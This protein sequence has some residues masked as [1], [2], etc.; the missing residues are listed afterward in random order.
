MQIDSDFL[1]LASLVAVLLLAPLIWIIG[2][3]ATAVRIRRVSWIAVHPKLERTGEEDLSQGMRVLLGRLAAA[4]RASGF[5]P[6]ESVHA[7][8]FSGFGAWTQVLY[9]HPTTGERASFINRVRAPGGSELQLLLA[10]ECPP[11]P[12]VITGLPDGPLRVDHDLAPQLADLIVRHRD[13]VRKACDEWHVDTTNGLPVGIA[14]GRDDAMRWLEQRAVT[15]AQHEATIFGYRIDPSGERYIAPWPLALRTA[16][17]RTF[18]LNRNP[19]SRAG[20]GRGFEALPAP[21]SDLK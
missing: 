10:T 18:S 11:H 4:L 7:P 1:K 9:V 19:A 17:R 16:A 8:A 13:A 2:V 12:S 14:P 15:I 5:E 3:A 6:I 20:V 21:S